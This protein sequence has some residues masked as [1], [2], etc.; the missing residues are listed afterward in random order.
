V[1]KD[2]FGTT[3]RKLTYYRY[4]KPNATAKRQ[5]FAAVQGI[6]ELFCRLPDSAFSTAGKLLYRHMG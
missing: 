5:P 6:R 3:R 1:F 2:R 4:E